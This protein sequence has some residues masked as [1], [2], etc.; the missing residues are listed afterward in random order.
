MLTGEASNSTLKDCARYAPDLCRDR[1]HV[2]LS[3]YHY[4]PLVLSGL[5]LLALGGLPFLLWGTFM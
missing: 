3:K 2:L 5:L 4:V 1:F